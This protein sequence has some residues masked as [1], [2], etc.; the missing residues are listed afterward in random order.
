MAIAT[1]VRT[2]SEGFNVI[3]YVSDDGVGIGI[4]FDG[5]FERGGTDAG[6]NGWKLV[7]KIMVIPMV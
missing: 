4:S 3:G 1:S 6:N 7:P 5:S 2:K